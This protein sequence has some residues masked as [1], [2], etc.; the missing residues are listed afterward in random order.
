MKALKAEV[1]SFEYH[2][3]TMRFPTLEEAGSIGKDV[4]IN[5]LETTGGHKFSPNHPANVLEYTIQDGEDT[6][7]LQ[8]AAHC[9]VTWD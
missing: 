1:L 4:R 8:E 2:K 9:K 3:V 6:S 7:P 5:G